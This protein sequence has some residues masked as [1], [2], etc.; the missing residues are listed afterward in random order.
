MKLEFF[1]E[2]VYSYIEIQVTL[3]K[4][5]IPKVNKDFNTINIQSVFD[6]FFQNNNRYQINTRP[7]NKVSGS[8][9]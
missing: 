2:L 7:K 1:S 8:Q 9:R 4:L 6:Q 3:Y 5:D